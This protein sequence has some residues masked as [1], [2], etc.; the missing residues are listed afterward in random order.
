VT[1]RPALYVIVSGEV[2]LT[3]SG[4]AEELAADEGDAV[5]VYQTLAGVPIACEA[6]VLHE[7]TALRIDRE[8]LFDLLSQRSDLLQQVFGALFRVRTDRVA[9]Q[10]S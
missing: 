7:G 5:G 1:D 8:E 3:P 9:S 2:T 4:D 10:A 6:R